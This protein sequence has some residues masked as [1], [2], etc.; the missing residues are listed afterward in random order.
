MSDYLEKKRR[1]P[2]LTYIQ[3]IWIGLFVLYPF[4][5]TYVDIKV[6]NTAFCYTEGSFIDIKGDDT[7]SQEKIVLRDS[8]ILEQSFVAVCPTITSI[9][10]NYGSDNTVAYGIYDFTL[11]DRLSGKI[12]DKWEKELNSTEEFEEV[13]LFLS[14]PKNI[15]DMTGKTYLLRVS[16]STK[17]IDHTAVFYRTLNDV[18]KDGQLLL[19]GKSINGDLLESIHGENSGVSLEYAKFCLRWMFSIC[20]IFV[21]IMI[22]NMNGRRNDRQ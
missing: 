2:K 22:F 3:W 8:D 5:S 19:D 10:V 4:L 12:V 7:V 13:E 17:S 20:V 18:Y 9:V 21:S 16:G 6:G 15:G 1:L 14:D 11:I